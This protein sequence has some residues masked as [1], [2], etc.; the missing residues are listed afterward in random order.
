MLKFELKKIFK[1]KAIFIIFIFSILMSV[2]SIFNSK[3]NRLENSY[4]TYSERSISAYLFNLVFRI[5]GE[6]LRESEFA[7]EF[8]KKF[9]GNED[10]DF[11]LYKI[12]NNEENKKDINNLLEKIK[13][14]SFFKLSSFKNLIK[15]Y[16]KE[17][18]PQDKL[19][20]NWGIF[21]YDYAIKNNV[22]INSNHN[23]HFTTN[24][25]RILI[26][27]SS[28]YLGLPILFLLIFLFYG[29]I[30][31]EIELGNY[32]YLKIQPITKFKIN[33]SKFI[34]IIIT[35]IF[36]LI[37]VISF[38][39]IISLI[40]GFKFTGFNEIYRVFKNLDN[41]YYLYGLS[42]FINIVINY[43]IILFLIS[44]I[45]IFIS[46][47]FNI[48]RYALIF[49]IFILPLLYLF[50]KYYK[51]LQTTYNPFHLI[52]YMK[53]ILG[54]Y[55]VEYNLKNEYVSNIVYGLNNQYLYK[56][57]ILASIFFAMSVIFRNIS[58]NKFDFSMFKYK[59]KSVYLFE[60]KKSLISK[61]I[62]VLLL[63]FFVIL[64]MIFIQVREEAIK[65][66]KILYSIKENVDK[67]YE[68]AKKQYEENKSFLLIYESAKE[69]KIFYENLVKSYEEKNSKLYYLTLGE[70]VNEYFSEGNYNLKD[71]KYSKNTI[72][73]T[74]KL[75]NYIKQNDIS[76]IIYKGISL[77]L[78]Q[79][80]KDPWSKEKEIK[81]FQIESSSSVFFFI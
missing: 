5:E 70:K 45:I 29:T 19:D 75:L 48:S 59:I 50:T 54:D 27:N 69:Y 1:K 68:E 23:S 56:I 34:S 22:D 30:S 38:I 15:K 64:T 46:N 9:S 36:Y 61:N 47:L 42:L 2:F 77:S 39:I 65:E 73:E 44:A 66:K 60:L 10:Y 32:N 74:N 53:N 80:Y 6:N 12:N 28:T 52:N 57:L 78:C 37:F 76:P 62:G 43:L 4:R 21:E 31:E 26:Y 67:S 14:Q 58:F 13:K 25:A 40:L 79:E 49:Y 11:Q 41:N 20:L 55:Q 24:I 72:Y 35:G 63:I 17:L 18:N 51:I 16:K 7:K 8:Y 3:Y 71:E 81:D 33:L